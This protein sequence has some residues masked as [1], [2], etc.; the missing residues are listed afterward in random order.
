MHLLNALLSPAFYTQF[1]VSAMQECAAYGYSY[2]DHGESLCSHI[3][4]QTVQSEK[5]VWLGLLSHTH[6]N[7]AA[8][9]HKI[10]PGPFFSR[11]KTILMHP[12]RYGCSACLERLTT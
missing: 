2:S 6:R 9:A 4:S 7:L 8:V 1:V 3:A 5:A 11:Q 12:P 10:W